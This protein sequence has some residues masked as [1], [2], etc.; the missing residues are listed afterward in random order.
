MITRA[1]AR[2]IA[3]TPAAQACSNRR[4]SGPTFTPPSSAN[5]IPPGEARMAT[6]M[7]SINESTPNANHGS[8]NTACRHRTI[9]DFPELDPPLSTIT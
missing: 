5:S 3:T 4:N 1:P 9:P 7:A 6:G 2:T 8:G